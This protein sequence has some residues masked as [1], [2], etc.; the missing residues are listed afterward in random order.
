MN[1]HTN[2]FVVPAERDPKDLAFVIVLVET[3]QGL[4]P[5]FMWAEKFIKEG[6][7]QINTDHDTWGQA[8]AKYSATKIGKAPLSGPSNTFEDG[9]IIFLGI[10][11]PDC[12]QLNEALLVAIEYKE[13]RTPL[14][15]GTIDSE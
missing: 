6:L 2:E 10:I 4:G 8:G 5:R 1:D 15:W 11:T 13:N 3:L 7:V 14:P 12:E 9:D